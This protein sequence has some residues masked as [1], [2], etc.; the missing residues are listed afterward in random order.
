VDVEGTTCE[1]CGDPLVWAKLDEEDYGPNEGHWFHE[2]CDPRH[3]PVFHWAVP[4]RPMDDTPNV[5][6][7]PADEGFMRP[8]LGGLGFTHVAQ[9]VECGGQIFRHPAWAHFGGTSSG[10]E[11]K[12]EA[13][14]GTIE[15]RGE[16]PEAV[17]LALHVI[18]S[19]SGA[20]KG[21]A[22]HCR[23]C[24][25]FWPCPTV[26]AFRVPTAHTDGSDDA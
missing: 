25:R 14:L 23:E 8:T 13:R 11:H 4:A 22:V 24:G 26:L 17:I 15:D 10:P 5:D 1:V 16:S 6:S 18:G 12:A 7:V 20:A 9:C 19:R 3:E 2:D 21:E